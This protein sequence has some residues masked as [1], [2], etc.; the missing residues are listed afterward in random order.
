MKPQD[1]TTANSRRLSEGTKRK[2]SFRYSNDS[3]NT[4]V[5]T[6]PKEFPL[7]E[8]T[9]RIISSAMEVHSTLGRGESFLVTSLYKNIYSV[10]PVVNFVTT[11]Y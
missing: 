7:K 8:V 5:K 10:N 6:S 1:L 11:F 9:E 3:V 4:V 2:K